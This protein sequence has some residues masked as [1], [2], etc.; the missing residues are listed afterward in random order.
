MTYQCCFGNKK[1]RCKSIRTT[2]WWL[3][4]N[5]G[6]VTVVLCRRHAPKSEGAE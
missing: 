5:K 6:T 3:R 1:G 4:Y 2:I